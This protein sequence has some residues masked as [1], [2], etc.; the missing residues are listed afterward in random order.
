MKKNKIKKKINDIIQLIPTCTE[1]DHKNWNNFL[2]TITYNHCIENQR[3][4]NVMCQGINC[5]KIFVGGKTIVEKGKLLW[6]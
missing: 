3:F 2:T 6:I 1:I 4:N 5:K